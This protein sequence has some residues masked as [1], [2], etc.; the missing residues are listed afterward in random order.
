MRAQLT[1]ARNEL[2]ELNRIG[3]ALMTERDRD[4]LLRQILVQAMRLTGSDGGALYLLEKGEDKT[5]RLRCELVLC[6]SLADL[7]SLEGVS[8]PVDST[9][10]AG[11]AAKTRQP[12]VIDDVYNLP[13]DAAYTLNWRVELQFDYWR[14]SMLTIPMVDHRDDTVGV[15]QLINRKS[16]PETRILKGRTS[17][18][19]S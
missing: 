19:T 10:V 12:L 9:S 6:D 15:L 14:K 17:T 18:A 2:I 13:G 1:R 4:T 11:H 3:M 7:T 8:F 16:D 5:E